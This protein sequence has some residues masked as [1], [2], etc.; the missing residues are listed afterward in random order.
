M[1]QTRFKYIERG[2]EKTII[3]VPGWATDY[4]IFDTLDLDFNYII[5]VDFHPSS[6]EKALLVILKDTKLKKVSFLGWSLGGFL[7]ADFASKHPEVTD[8]LILI[9]IRRKYKKEEIE[10]ART[11]LERSKIGYLYKFYSACLPKGSES[12]IFDKSLFKS[13]QEEL[14]LDYLLESLDY[15]EKSEINPETLKRFKKIKIIHGEKDTIAPIREVASL[16]EDLPE[17]D[18]IKIEKASHMPFL[19]K[20]FKGTI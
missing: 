16:K 11:L 14:E 6:F 3:L 17:A 13:Y 4:R 7:A 15:L 9:G 1:K 19:E 2:K 12:G 8:E 18:F 10:K 5:P 20:E